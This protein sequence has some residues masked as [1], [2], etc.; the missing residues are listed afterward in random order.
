MN[1]DTRNLIERPYQEIV[2]DLLTA[3]VGGV[4]NEPLL[5]DVKEDLYPLAEPAREIRGIT[6]TRERARHSF[7]KEID[8]LFS[9]GDNAVVWQ[10][11]GARPDDETTFYVDYFRRES[12]SPLT[13]INVGSVTRTL[14]EAIGREIAT[15]YQ[16]INQAYLAGFIET[17]EGTSLDLVVAI[18]GVVRQT[19]DY[20][21]GLATFFRDPA[22]DG[23]IT[24]PEA[25]VLTT[26]K[27]EAGFVTT[28]QRT[29]QRGQVRIDVPIRAGADFKGEAGKVAAG[30]ITTLAATI[31]GIAKVTNFEATFLGAKDETDEELR[32]RAR[33]VLRALGKGTLAALARVIFEGR[34]ELVEYWDPAGP[35]AKQAPLGT[36]TLLVEAEPERFPSLQAAVHETRAAGVL[37]TLVA[38]Y[39]FCKPRARVKIAAGLTAAGKDKVKGEII[40]AVQAYVD[41]LTAGDA[42]QGS[43]LLAAC[44][45]VKEVRDALI[46]DVMAWRS[47]LGTPGGAGLAD[48]LAAAL[49]GV[50]TGDPAA[51]R[52]AIDQVLE[53][54]APAPPGGRRIPDRSL[55]QGP[56]GARATDEEIE[57]GTF[58]VA[59]RIGN[60]DWWV[61]LDLEPADI[62]LEEG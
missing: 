27:G 22:V 28:Q 15:V 41:G 2:D 12:D 61:V 21:V 13:D 43:D 29:L 5:Y 31:A 9:E 26:E 48:S 24:I 40:A 58:S 32:A 18:L 20:A 62:A 45:S 51:L 3:V 60:E 25:V 36:V 42:A 49:S 54:G 30:K 59:A 23:N 52:A 11:G 46:V 34:G 35:P 56:S 39:V 55:V 17:A 10:P 1:G 33:A 7:L 37:A 4:V 14:S 8:F 50:P 44:K 47:D 53:T 16:Q 38:R 6:G 57:A 19:K